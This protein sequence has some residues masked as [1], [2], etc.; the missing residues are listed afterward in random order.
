M[1]SSGVTLLALMVM[2]RTVS[3]GSK[4]T[5][6]DQAKEALNGADL[7]FIFTEWDEVRALTPED[8][9]S[10]MKTPIILDG[11]NCYS[12]ESFEARKVVYDSIGRKTVNT[13]F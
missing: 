2:R 10:R 4:L 3:A 8:F 12:V 1:P 9:C 6:C 5:Y 11:R 7:C 13:L